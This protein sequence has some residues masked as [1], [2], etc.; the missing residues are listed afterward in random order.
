MNRVL[1]QCCRTHTQPQLHAAVDLISSPQDLHAF[2][3]AP[4]H[5]QPSPW[6]QLR[7]L[8]EQRAELLVAVLDEDSSSV[9]AWQQEWQSEL[10][11]PSASILAGTRV[12][13]GA[14]WCWHMALASVEKD[15]RKGGPMHAIIRLG[16]RAEAK[17]LA[18]RPAPLPLP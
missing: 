10:T 14:V 18:V 2:D 3:E 17:Y 11:R 16:R 13:A 15:R 9:A 4:A 8:M 5:T 1:H 6:P 7:Q 12:R